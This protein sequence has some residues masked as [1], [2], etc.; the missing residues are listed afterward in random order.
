MGPPPAL[1]P[2]TPPGRAEEPVVSHARTRTPPPHRLVASSHP[3]WRVLRRSIGI[4]CGDHNKAFRDFSAP[5]APRTT[6]D[7]PRGPLKIKK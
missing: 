4:V 3:W 1:P 2:S 7:G 5:A 6:R